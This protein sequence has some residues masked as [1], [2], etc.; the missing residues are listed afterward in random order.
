M[1]Y[2]YFLTMNYTPGVTSRFQRRLAEHEEP[3]RRAANRL[4]A[5]PG[6]L[7]EASALYFLS[8][9]QAGSCQLSTE[10][11]QRPSLCVELGFK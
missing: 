9:L 7:A 6:S 3:T 8:L 5:K 1:N 4:S 2:A 10:R 11:V